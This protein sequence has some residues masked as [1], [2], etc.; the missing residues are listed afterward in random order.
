LLLSI[1]A[2]PL[3]RLFWEIERHAASEL[4]DADALVCAL[5]AGID[6]AAREPAAEFQL[7]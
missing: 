4:I 3:P 7:K 2:T 6:S 1:A 5:E